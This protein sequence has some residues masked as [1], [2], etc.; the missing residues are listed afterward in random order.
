MV[1]LG[2]RY[3]LCQD[4]VGGWCDSR[5]CFAARALGRGGTNLGYADNGAMILDNP[6]AMSNVAG[7]G[8]FDVGGDGVMSNLRYSDPTRS[9]VSTGFTPLPQI[10]YV[11]KSA[12]GDW[13]FGLGLF[14]PAGFSS[15]YYL[16]PTAFPAGR[17]VH[18]NAKV[19][20]IRLAEQ[21][22]ARPLL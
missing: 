10:G 19:R 5:R 13:S 4:Y 12:D 21:G 7:D 16:T 1:G 18:W 17:A 8:L 15:H 11:R 2:H 6:A 3:C 9:G 20:I 14:T 22:P